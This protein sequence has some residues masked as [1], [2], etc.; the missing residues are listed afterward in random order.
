MSCSAAGEYLSVAANNYV[1]IIINNNNY[2]KVC[3]SDCKTDEHTFIDITNTK[4]VTSCDPDERYYNF[5]NSI[6]NKRYLRCG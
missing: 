5:F 6:I 1:I 4:C 2:Y 3:V